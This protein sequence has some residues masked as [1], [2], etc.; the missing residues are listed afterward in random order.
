MP[1]NNVII[2][3]EFPKPNFCI[4]FTK[5]NRYFPCFYDFLLSEKYDIYQ[6]FKRDFNRTSVFGKTEK[7]QKTSVD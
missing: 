4:L 2:F 5:N 1:H 3:I 6:I 7:T